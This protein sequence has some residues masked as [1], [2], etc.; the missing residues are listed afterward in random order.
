MKRILLIL[1]VILAFKATIRAQAYDGK[2]DYQKTQQQVAIIE[3]PYNQDVVQ[4]GIK[5]Y[6]AKRGYKKTNAKGF[7]V[8]RSAKLDS[9]DNDLSDLYFKIERKGRKEKDVT[10]ITLLPAKPNQDIIARSGDSTAGTKIEEAKSFLNNIA[11]YLDARN[12]DAQYSAQQEVLKKSQKKLNSLM[13][14]QND[15]QKKI[16]KIQADQD[17]N[18]SDILKQTQDIQTIVTSD[19][20]VKNKMQKRMNKLLD[21]Q[22][23]LRKKLR[24]VQA[25]LD[26]N[27]TNQEAQQ[28]DVDTQQQVLDAIKAKQK[29]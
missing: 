14:D 8:F 4:D 5:D 22:D 21:Q 20:D 2:L 13:N 12:I 18:K 19:A 3:L 7:D 24:K 25:D 15:L 23:D 6:M 29:S 11:P 1:M 17:Q 16:R 27:R 28:K 26:E 10:V 9:S